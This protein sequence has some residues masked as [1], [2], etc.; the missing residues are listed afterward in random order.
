MAKKRTT[1][2]ETGLDELFTRIARQHLHVETLE[3]RGR[4]HLDFHDVSVAGIAKAL[5]AAYDAGRES[6][7][8]TRVAPS[9]AL[10]AALASARPLAWDEQEAVTRYAVTLDAGE[11]QRLR[12]AVGGDGGGER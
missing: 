9:P 7:R 6:R 11:Y 1:T 4:D 5:R 12:R 8:A 3:T 10:R 2:T